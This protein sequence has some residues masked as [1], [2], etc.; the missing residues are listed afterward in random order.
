MRF[1]RVDCK[2]FFFG[3][4]KSKS[5]FHQKLN[6]RVLTWT[7]IFRRLHKKGAVTELK[8]KRTRKT[9]FK[10]Q[11]GYVGASVE[12]IL[13]KRNLKPEQRAD[14]RAA[15]LREVKER[16][17][18]QKAA[19]AALKQQTAASKRAPAAASKQKRQM[20][21]KPTSK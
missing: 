16:K 21:P 10:V 6:P 11:R 7:Q 13:K 8:K 17:A 14:A 4:K 2:T 1:I 15:A 5:L 3:D 20:K 12:Q 9:V 19:K 18:G